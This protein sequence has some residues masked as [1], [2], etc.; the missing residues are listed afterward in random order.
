MLNQATCAASVVVSIHDCPIRFSSLLFNRCLL[1]FI[2]IIVDTPMA[3]KHQQHVGHNQQ[4]SLHFIIF[5]LLEQTKVLLDD[6][7]VSILAFEKACRPGI[8][9]INDRWEQ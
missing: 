6:I 1:S 3:H 5:S 8:M 2:R 7:P 9:G 4:Y